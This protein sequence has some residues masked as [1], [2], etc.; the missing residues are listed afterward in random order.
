MKTSTILKERSDGGC[1]CCRCRAG[2]SL[3]ADQD[4][5]VHRSCR[6]RRRP[7]TRWRAFIDGVVKKHQLMKA[8]LVVINKSG[9]AGAEGFLDVKAPRATRTRLS[10]RSPTCSLRRLRPVCRSTGRI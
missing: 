8:P 3:G 5:R 10:S 2:A 9:G 1:A 6:D 7:P 4:G